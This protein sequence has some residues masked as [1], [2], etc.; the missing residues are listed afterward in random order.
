MFKTSAAASV[1]IQKVSGIKR[2]SLEVELIDRGVETVP[3]IAFGRK[4]FLQDV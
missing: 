3:K 2:E 1:E 4:G